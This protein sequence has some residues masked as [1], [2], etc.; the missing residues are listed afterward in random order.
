MAAFKSALVTPQTGARGGEQGDI[1]SAANA[2]R[3]GPLIPDLVIPDDSLNNLSDDA[4]FV[5]AHTIA[6]DPALVVFVAVVD[7]NFETSDRRTIGRSRA[8]RRQ[9]RETGL[10]CGL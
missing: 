6:V 2:H 10:P 9:R 1:A 4:R 3:S 5:L 8:G 7:R